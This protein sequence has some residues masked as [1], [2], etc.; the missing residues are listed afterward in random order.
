M[1][2][3]QI[4]QNLVPGADIGENIQWSAYKVPGREGVEIYPLYNT[5]DTGSNGPS[6]ALVRYQAGAQV[7]E[8]LHPGYELIYVL[9]GVLENDEGS[10][11]PGTLQ[12]CP[13]G[14]THALG[15]EQGCTFLVVWEQ[16]VELVTSH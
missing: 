6:A 7:Q 5:D 12:V 8:H 4:I 13:P 9:E 15:S 10:Q 11:Y 3:A 14:S 2:G 1:R 16:P